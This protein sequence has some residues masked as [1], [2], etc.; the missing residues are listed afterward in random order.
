MNLVGAWAGRIARGLERLDIWAEWLLQRDEA[1]L[2]WFGRLSGLRRLEGTWVAL[3][4]LGDGYVW[5]LLALY[6]IMFGGSADRR[7]VLVT[8]GLMTVVMSIVRLFKLLFSRPRPVLEGR[9]GRDWYVDTFGFPSGH[10][11]AAFTVAYAVS[12]FYPHPA[13]VAMIYVLATGIGLSRVYLR[14]HYPLD[15]LGG[16]LL[17]S[18]SAHILL[19]LFGR[20]LHQARW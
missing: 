11:T 20:I 5:G 18:L 1:A 19:P 14:D 15:V 16:A 17:G 4:Y 9:P 8:M 2:D 7:N 10:T 13:I 3:T 6:L 12:S